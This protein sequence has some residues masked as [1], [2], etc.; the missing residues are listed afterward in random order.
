MRAAFQ[1]DSNGPLEDGIGLCLSGGGYRAML[2]HLGSLWRMNE[3]GLLH[4]DKLKRVSSVSGGSITAAVLGMNWNQLAFNPEGIAT[5]ESFIAAVIQPVRR[6]ADESIDVAAVGWGTFNPFKSIS[7]VVEGYYRDYVFKK[8]TLQDLPD[9]PRF[10][11]NATNVQSGSLFRFSKPYMVDYQVARWNHPTVPLARVVAASSA[12]PPFLS[13]CTLDLR[14]TQPAEVY[15]LGNED[16]EHYLSQICLTDGGVYDNLGLEPVWKNFKIVLCS[17]GGRKS[18]FDPKPASDWALHSR[19]LIELLERQVSA[20]RKKE[21]I[22]SFLAIGQTIHRTGAYW[23]I[24][25]PYQDYDPATLAPPGI[26]LQ[27]TPGTEVPE[28]AHLETRLT[29]VLTETQEAL[30]NWGYASA[31]AALRR[32]FSPTVTSTPQLPYA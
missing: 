1:M 15:T 26:D 16:S 22:A 12:F 30:I 23:G 25:T 21:L 10:V 11:L 6:L 18:A 7:D 17:D 9:H 19:R 28:V 32:Y 13:P 8:K 14:S 3:L 4:P 29:A 20:L 5:T 27:L 24:T 31:D 2:Y